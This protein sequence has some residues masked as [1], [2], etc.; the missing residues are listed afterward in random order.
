MTGEPTLRLCARANGLIDAIEART[1]AFGD[2]AGC[3]DKLDGFITRAGRDSATE[4]DR[5]ALAA[6]LDGGKEIAPH[7]VGALRD[8]WHCWD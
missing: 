7:E 1:L 2:G 5:A 8:A 3:D 4:E 6:F